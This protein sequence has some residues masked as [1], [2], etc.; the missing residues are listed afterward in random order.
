MD[1]QFVTPLKDNSESICTLELKD[2]TAVLKTKH[3]SKQ[4][5]V[6]SQHPDQQES[7]LHSLEDEQH[8]FH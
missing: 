8:V 3:S 5:I 4:F 1:C 7:T 2:N 6:L